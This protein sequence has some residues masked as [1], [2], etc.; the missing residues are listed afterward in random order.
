MLCFYIK[1]SLSLWL[2]V[3]G[4]FK[5]SLPYANLDVTE[6]LHREFVVEE[7]KVQYQLELLMLKGL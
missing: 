3:Y 1:Y 5:K 7:D 2:E 4:W 6:K